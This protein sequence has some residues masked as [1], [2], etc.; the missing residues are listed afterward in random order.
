MKIELLERKN[1]IYEKKSKISVGLDRAEEKTSEHGD[2]AKESIQNEMEE[3]EERKKE[4]RAGRRE[5]GRAG[6]NKGRNEGREGR[7]KKKEGIRKQREKKRK[8][9]KE[10]NITEYR[11]NFKWSNAYITGV[12]EEYKREARGEV[13]GGENIYR[14]FFKFQIL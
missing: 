14:N 1:A 6:R 10:T 9:K 5:G 8:G 11:D 2:M 7:K 3:K 12:P 13:A 4:R